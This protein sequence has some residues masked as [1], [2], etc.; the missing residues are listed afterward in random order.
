MADAQIL[1]AASLLVSEEALSDLTLRAKGE[2]T[3]A[4]DDVGTEDGAT[5]P[6]SEPGEDE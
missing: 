3:V 5:A 1:G 6:A 2:K 4:A